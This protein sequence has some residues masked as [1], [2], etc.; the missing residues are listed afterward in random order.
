M[1]EACQVLRVVS[2]ELR[3]LKLYRCD[4][5]HTRMI[6]PEI[7]IVLIRFIDKVR[8][9]AQAIVDPETGYDKFGIHQYE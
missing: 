4:N 3:V 9:L 8:A 5:G 1:F 2:K 7:V 6:M